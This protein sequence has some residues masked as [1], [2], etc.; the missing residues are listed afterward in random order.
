[1]RSV[2]GVPFV[3]EVGASQ[4]TVAAR[5]VPLR[6]CGAVPGAGPGSI[7]PG[8]SDDATAINAPRPT[9]VFLKASPQPG[10]CTTH[11]PCVRSGKKPTAAQANPQ[12]PL[13]LRLSKAY[14]NGRITFLFSS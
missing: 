10:R 3:L 4:E 8:R 12:Q 14:A 2:R 5:L 11:P 1:M 6:L 13:C 9:S 7:H